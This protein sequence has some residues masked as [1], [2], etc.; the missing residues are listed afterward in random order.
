[1]AHTAGQRKSQMGKRGPVAKG[2]MTLIYSP[3]KFQSWS[4]KTDNNRLG[5][6]GRMMTGY[7]KS[8]EPSGSNRDIR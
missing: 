1:M 8:R 6:G 7:Q 4:P 3:C 5:A 2:T